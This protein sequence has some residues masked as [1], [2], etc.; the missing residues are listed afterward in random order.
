VDKDLTATIGDDETE[1]LL[2]AEPLDPPMEFSAIG[3]FF[4]AGPAHLGRLDL[5]APVGHLPLLFHREDELFAA[6]LASDE[7]VSIIHCGF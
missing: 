5:C 4:G 2:Q 3:D 1:S 6:F 7:G